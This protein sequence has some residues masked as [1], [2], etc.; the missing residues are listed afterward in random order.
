MERGTYMDILK[1]SEDTL[2]V[3][4]TAED[5]NAY[6]LDYETIENDRT[7]SVFIL[8][9]I[10]REAS[11]RC[12]FSSEGSKFYVQLYASFKGECEIFVRR[13]GDARMSQSDYKWDTKEYSLI[14]SVSHGGMYVYSFDAMTPM[15]QA[16][17]RLR[18]ARY[19][20]ESNAYKEHGGRMYYLVLEERSPLPE[21]QGG[22]L[23]ERNASYY[24]KEHC[25][26]ICEGAVELLGRLV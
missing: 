2:K 18:T 10:L 22:R 4:L 1:I 13:L 3:M 24:I 9:E 15:L 17:S 7:Q 25:K 14:P 19:N 26:L 12:G 21:E 23:C 16:C 6:S 8:R 11:D 20:G 5:M